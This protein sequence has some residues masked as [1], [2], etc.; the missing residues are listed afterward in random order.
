MALFCAAIRRDY[1][2]H[3]K[4][5]F[6]SHVL[7][8]SCEML[9]IS[10]LKCPWSCFSSHFCFI[11]IVIL[12]SIV[13]S[14]LFLMAVISP[15]SSFSMLSS[16]CCMDVLT[17]SLM[18]ASPLPPSF[19]GTY[20]LST[21]SQGCNAFFIVISFLLLWSICLSSFLVYLRKGPEYLTRGTDLVF[22]HL[23]RYLLLSFVSS[24]FLFLLR[25]S[26]KILFF[27]STC[28]MV[29]AFKILKYL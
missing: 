27:I 9:F 26:F 13:L 4:F 25:Y 3:L 2:S 24:S 17:L 23:I 15:G 19:F 18:L 20:S 28:L 5:P 29:S 22:I 12:L 11:V 16:S 8:L 10:R 1:V 7:V 14:V 21:S 6:L